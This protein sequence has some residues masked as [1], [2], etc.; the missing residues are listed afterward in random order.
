MQ[1]KDHMIAIHDAGVMHAD[2]NPSHAVVSDVDPTDWRII[3]F[4][5]ARKHECERQMDVVL[6]QW[7]PTRLEFRCAHLFNVI[8]MLD[9]WTPS[10]SSAN[11]GVRC[12]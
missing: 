1:I 9:L 11:K 12:H 10:K 2:F 7:Q 3:D 6:Y 5:W 8:H 4:S